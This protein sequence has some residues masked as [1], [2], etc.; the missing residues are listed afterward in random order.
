MIYLVLYII[1]AD[2]LVWVNTGA[3]LLNSNSSYYYLWTE[4]SAF[5]GVLWT[6]DHLKLQ[7]QFPS[8]FSNRRPH[9]GH[10]H[11]L[12]TSFLSIIHNGKL[13]Y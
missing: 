1:L 5:Y 9:S 7:E 4:E 12:N 8:Q 13:L 6:P 11:S 2:C 3:K 10:S